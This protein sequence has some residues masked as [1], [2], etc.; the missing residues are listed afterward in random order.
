MRLSKD[1]PLREQTPLISVDIDY[2]K[3]IPITSV[4]SRLGM[5]FNRA[6]FCYCPD[7]NCP[8]NTSKKRGAHVNEKDNT[9]H[10]FV[11]GG[12]WNPFTLT[13]LKQFGYD[14][15]LCYTREGI[16]AI[17]KFIAEDLGF[18]EIKELSP[19]KEESLYPPMPD[20]T[21]H[22]DEQTKMK[23]TTVPLWRAIGLSRNPFSTTVA[24]Q[25]T[26]KSG[27]KQSADMA[28]PVHEAALMVTMKCLETMQKISDYMMISEDETS[29]DISFINDIEYER[30]VLESYIHKI[31]PLLDDDA[32]K[33]ITCE[34][35]YQYVM[36]KDD[37]HRI[38]LVKTFPEEMSVIT[39]NL[40]KLYE[41]GLVKPDIEE[42]KDSTK[43]DDDYDMER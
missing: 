12:T 35:L 11:C 37:I 21:F 24:V 7:P 42:E 38:H 25:T 1:S 19:K 39:E 43:G 5:N 33:T 14:T 41:N 3:S 20:I 16:V 40:K 8:D 15:G 10:C 4:A 28:L 18:G 2:Q 13:G 22:T 23:G 27:I 26:E 17:G 9:I 29:K 32:K 34:L 36:T 6:K 30:I 31:Y